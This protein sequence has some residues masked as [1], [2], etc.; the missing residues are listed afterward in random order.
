[1]RKKLFP[2]YSTFN[3]THPAQKASVSTVS[4]H[5][6]NVLAAICTLLSLSLPLANAQ[7]NE[8]WL[9]KGFHEDIRKYLEAEIKAPIEYLSI[10]IDK[11]RSENVF[12]HA[13][14]KEGEMQSIPEAEKDD[15]LITL[16]Y[17]QDYAVII[18]R[19]DDTGRIDTSTNL[20][21]KRYIMVNGGFSLEKYIISRKQ[22]LSYNITT[23][24]TPFN[25]FSKI[26]KGEADFTVLPSL[27]AEKL[28]LDTGMMNELYVYGSPDDTLLKFSY[29]FAIKKSDKETFLKLNDAIS[30]LYNNG[31][32][33]EIARKDLIPPIYVPSFAEVPA[34]PLDKF[35]GTLNILI[36]L[37]TISFFVLCIFFRHKNHK[38]K[39]ENHTEVPIMDLET[40]ELKRISTG[41][42]HVDR[43]IA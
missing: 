18:S 37:S 13:I 15:F 1:M 24:T 10:S 19:K 17:T 32:I 20:E 39:Q 6:K 36:I 12:F 4:T 26:F 5:I 30:R 27:I 3:G 40:L 23:D 41:Q 38:R 28:L 25:S 9:S 11:F 31:T 14:S 16:P 7:E 35:L 42:S 43:A 2:A 29:R 34:S 33:Y 22:K 21:Q 8:S